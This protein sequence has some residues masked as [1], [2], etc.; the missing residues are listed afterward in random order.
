MCRHDVLRKERA[1]KLATQLRKELNVEK[2]RTAMLEREL[3]E[4]RLAATSPQ[5]SCQPGSLPKAKRKL[6]GRNVARSSTCMRHCT[7]LLDGL[8]QEL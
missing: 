7:G 8:Q 4:A 5:Q 3:K 2:F 1:G 6:V